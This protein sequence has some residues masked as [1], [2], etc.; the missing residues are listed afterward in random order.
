MKI[1]VPDRYELQI[2]PWRIEW[3]VD[4]WC[5]GGRE[6]QGIFQ[7]DT[8]CPVLPYSSLGF[9]FLPKRLCVLISGPHMY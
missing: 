4:P 9:Y 5:K 7:N 1:S 2:E 8:I 6:E 3:L